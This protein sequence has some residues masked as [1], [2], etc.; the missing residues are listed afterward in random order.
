MNQEELDND[1][2]NR[3]RDKHSLVSER[4]NARFR[5]THLTLKLDLEDRGS[6]LL[7]EE[8]IDVDITEGE[9]KLIKEAKAIESKEIRES[10]VREIRSEDSLHKRLFYI[11][12]KIGDFDYTLKRDKEEALQGLCDLDDEKDLLSHGDSKLN[13]KKFEKIEY[14]KEIY[15]KAQESQNFKELYSLDL[16]FQNPILEDL[17]DN[18][19]RKYNK[20]VNTRNAEGDS[21]LRLLEL[22]DVKELDEIEEDTKEYILFNLAEK[23]RAVAG[24][25]SLDEMMEFFVFPDEKERHIFVQTSQYSDL[26]DFYSYLLQNK[27]IQNWNVMGVRGFRV[28]K[29]AFEKILLR[30]LDL[31]GISTTK[32]ASSTE[33]ERLGILKDKLVETYKKDKKYKQYFKGSKTTKQNLALSILRKRMFDGSRLS[34]QEL[35][36]MPRIGAFITL[37]PDRGIVDESVKNFVHTWFIAWKAERILEAINYEN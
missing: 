29:G 13:K 34:R 2:I 16:Y 4:I 7:A 21:L 1:I 20:L 19:I 33:G 22:Q 27:D 32:T 26:Q 11:C 8:D 12:S 18:E 30:H 10:E 35:E 24:F 6:E 28:N 9:L 37:H 15:R 31:F 25:N 23:A 3:F 36:I 17:T 14:Y 5:D